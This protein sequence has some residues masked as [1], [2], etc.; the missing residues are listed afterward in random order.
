MLISI[1][2]DEYITV[3]VTVTTDAPTLGLFYFAISCLIVKR[4][5]SM[6]VKPGHLKLNL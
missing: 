6:H 2:T 4:K 1:N 5:S 3:R